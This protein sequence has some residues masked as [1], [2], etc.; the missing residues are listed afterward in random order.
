MVIELR[1]IILDLV[2]FIF[3]SCGW[4]PSKVI[5]VV[6]DWHAWSGEGL[7]F[8]KLT[9]SSSYLKA[10]LWWLVLRSSCVSTRISILTWL[11]VKK[12]GSLSGTNT[13]NGTLKFSTGANPYVWVCLPFFAIIR[14]EK[15][16]KMVSLLSG[17]RIRTP[18][19][20]SK[21]YKYPR[22]RGAVGLLS[23]WATWWLPWLLLLEQEQEQDP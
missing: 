20:L 22:L 8:T 3:K 23:S 1:C 4:V 5:G 21:G 19:L 9:V 12:A 13:Y 2:A 15:M 6:G 14:A 10:I 7:P 17:Q 18:L 16:A 11:S